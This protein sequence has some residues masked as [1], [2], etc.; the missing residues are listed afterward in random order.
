MI[1]LT[2]A[3]VD[4]APIFADIFGADN[5]PLGSYVNEWGIDNN[6]GVG[7]YVDVTCAREN[8]N[9]GLRI[10]FKIICSDYDYSS[11]VTGYNEE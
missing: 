8:G 10:W 3:G 11:E 1:I 9:I 6:W 5:D 7:N 2:I 4:F